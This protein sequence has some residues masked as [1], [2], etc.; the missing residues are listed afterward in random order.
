[1][2]RSIIQVLFAQGIVLVASI[3]KSLILPVVLDVD[4]FAYWQVYVLYSGF[5]GVFALGYSDG[6]YLK[7]GGCDYGDLPFDRLRASV[8]VYLFSL[9]AFSAV[10]CGLSL[11]DPDPRHGFALFFVGVD[12]LFTCLSGLLLYVL[13]I[14]NQIKSYSFFVTVDKIMMVVLIGVIVVASPDLNF[15]LVVIIDVMTK[16]VVCIAL[17]FRC[18][19]LFLGAAFSFFDGVRDYFEEARVG[20][21]LLVANLAGMLAVNAGRFIVEIMGSTADYAYYS[22]GVSVTNL[23]LSFVSAT[24][25]VIY[26]NLKRMEPSRVRSF[27]DEVDAISLKVISVGLMLYAPCVLFVVFII[28]KYEPMLGYLGFMFLAV[29]G[30]VKMQ[31]LG[32]TYYKALRK[33]RRMLFVNMQAVAMFFI[34]GGASYLILKSVAAIAASTAFVLLYRAWASERELRREL[35]LAGRSC[36]VAVEMAFCIAFI[37]AAL[38]PIREVSLV[39]VEVV[40]MAGLT[41]SLVHY[42]RTP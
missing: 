18:R 12:I 7:F 31:L 36:K 40:G 4:G 37:V 8:R 34:V 28:P 11:F 14:T 15:R 29:A 19:E 20:F 17:V 27:F 41:S 35:R 24:A 13:Q 16:V 2:R 30:Q 5:V 10:T 23:V 32:N 42:G 6:I 9:L 39:L 22:F 38:L 26:P 3:L 1:M 25:L 21:S 33:E